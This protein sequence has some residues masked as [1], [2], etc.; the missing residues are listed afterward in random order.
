MQPRTTNPKVETP[1]AYDESEWRIGFAVRDLPRGKGQNRWLDPCSI[2]S[3][4]FLYM[5][6]QPPRPLRILV[7]PDLLSKYQ[8]IFALNLRLLRVE[9]VVRMLH[10]LSRSH[11]KPLFDTLAKTNTLFMHFRFLAHTFVAQLCSYIYDTG[12]RR[13]FDSLLLDISTA[14]EGRNGQRFSD[15]FELARY[16]SDVLDNILVACLLRS[17]QKVA[18][19]ALRM[20]LE[21]VMELGILAGELSRGRIEEHQAK[22]TLEELYSAFK[23]RVSRLV[24]ILE[25]L[26]DK[27]LEQEGAG[28]INHLFV[29]LDPSW[30]AR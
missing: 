25:I 11:N 30:W 23:R 22:S 2:E 26:K 13:H 16:H 7:G 20:C 3:L 8:R 17:G 15:V 12:I 19:D 21:T 14:K 29:K 28:S 10:R 1:S 27:E 9:N 6:Y 4:D 5:E 18:G 24:R